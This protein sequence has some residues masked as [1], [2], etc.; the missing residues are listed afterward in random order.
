MVLAISK[1]EK[2]LETTE[3]QSADPPDGGYGW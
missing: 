3:L 1:D 2:S